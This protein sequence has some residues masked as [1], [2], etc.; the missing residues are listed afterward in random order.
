MHIFGTVFCLIWME[1]CYINMYAS[2]KCKSEKPGASCEDN[3]SDNCVIQQKLE[4]EPQK[5]NNIFFIF[6]LTK[7]FVLYFFCA[8]NSD[9][10]Y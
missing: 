10:E 4:I 2:A 1:S 9:N 7:E 3:I 5:L 8:I 6:D